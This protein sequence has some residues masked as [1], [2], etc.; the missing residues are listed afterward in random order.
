MSSA[1]LAE[2]RLSKKSLSRNIATSSTSITS[3]PVT[4]SEQVLSKSSI[5]RRSVTD[6]PMRYKQREN[7]LNI[8]TTTKSL[9]NVRASNMEL[10]SSTND[11]DVNSNQKSQLPS[12]V[13]QSLSPSKSERNKV[14]DKVI[15]Q[16]KFCSS[17]EM[18]TRYRE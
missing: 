8:N 17:E 18:R 7:L 16:L 3:A 15:E 10:S 13:S 9:K 6:K 1:S 4:P 11:F 2:K 5:T 12:K 14:D